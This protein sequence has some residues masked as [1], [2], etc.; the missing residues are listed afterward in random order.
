MSA[1]KDAV[2]ADVD[3]VFINEDEF[4][5]VHTLGRSRT[6][7]RCIID[8]DVTAEAELERYGVFTNTLTIHVPSDALPEVPV[9]GERF[10]VDDS[11]H[12]VLSV[13]NEAGVLVIT[14]EANGQ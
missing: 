11:L 14:C 2:A 3:A 1:F 8:K 6:P 5:E 10:S 13:S 7:V 4:A 12:V 9:E